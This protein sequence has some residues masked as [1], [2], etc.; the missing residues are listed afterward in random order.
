MTTTVLFW[1]C[2]EFIEVELPQSHLAGDAVFSNAA[3]ANSAL[4]DIY[5]RLRDNGFSS[6]TQISATL[7]MG[8]YA[9]EYAFYGT[10]AEIGQFSNHTLVTSN[11][12]L[13]SLWNMSYSTIYAANALREGVEKSDA[14]SGDDRDRL[15]GETLFIRAYMHF[16]LVN[17]F[18]DVPYV[19]TTNYN[20]NKSIYKTSQSE[21]YQLILDDLVQAAEL[22]PTTYPTTERVRVNKAVVKALQARVNLYVGNW[23]EAQ[24]AAT[25]IINNA[26]YSWQPD[27]TLTFLKD[28]PAIIWSLHPGMSGSNTHDAR[29]FA[30]FDGPPFKSIL[31]ADLFNAFEIGDNRKALWIKQITNGIETWYQPSKYKNETETA[32]SEEYSILFRLEEQFLIR[33]EARAHLGD[34]LGAQEDLN[35]TRNRAGLPNTTATSTE[36]LLNA[37]LEERRFEL[38]SEQGHRWYDLKRTGRAAAVLSLIK[39]GWRATDLLLPIPANEI[40]LN[41]NLLPQNPGY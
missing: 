19:L 22:L 33:A 4:S 9:D 39:P 21:V 3:T 1:S 40:I 36:A 34:L 16:F 6:G 26:D 2:E 18:G 20:L 24:N 11:S 17:S 35:M 31:S 13:A 8:S 10:N 15:L 30:I 23:E 5:A 7:L 38:F 41:S 27:L 28:N 32:L 29:T 14:I 37:I 12:L 25:E